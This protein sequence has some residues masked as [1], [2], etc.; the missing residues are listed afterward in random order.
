M[1]FDSGPW[2]MPDKPAGTWWGVSVDDGTEWWFP[3]RGEL[4]KSQLF[5]LVDLRT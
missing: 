5:A 4:V 1:Q 2:Q 3:L